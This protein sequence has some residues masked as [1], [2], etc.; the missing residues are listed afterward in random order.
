ME[1]QTKKLNEDQINSLIL[2]SECPTNSLNIL[3][4]YEY[5]TNLVRLNWNDILFLIDNKYMHSQSAV[6]HAVMEISVNENYPK[7]VLELAC[8]LSNES[9]IALIYQCLNDLVINIA[10]NV[11]IQTK[12]KI[13]YILLSWI[14]EH[15]NDYANALRV[16]EIIYDD[17]GFPKIISDFV[18]YMPSDLPDLDSEELH[19]ER[20]YNNWRSYLEKQ[21][22]FWNK[23]DL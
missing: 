21:A 5:A 15:R 12:E 23:K 3:I 6:E 18:R 16:V 7:P 14:Y 20:I 19:L 2:N 17:F 9:H 22:Q 4:P 8:L 13:M 11:K 10:E 1:N